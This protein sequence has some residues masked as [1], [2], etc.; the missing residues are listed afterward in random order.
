MYY[1]TLKSL[2]HV[3]MSG[4]SRGAGSQPAAASQAA[5]P[6]IENFRSFFGGSAF[7]C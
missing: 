2:Q 5:F 7:A 4:Q 6:P 3:T 1:K